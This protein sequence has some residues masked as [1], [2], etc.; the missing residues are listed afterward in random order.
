MADGS[1]V[2]GVSLDMAA[3]SASVAAMEAQI[4]GLGARI[5]SSIASSFSAGGIA[6]GFEASL[7]GVSSAISSLA[8]SISSSMRDVAA[9]SMEAFSSCDWASCG[10]AA[11]V[12]IAAGINSGI[13]AVTSAIDSITSA[14]RAA[15]SGW[16]S[17]GGDMMRGIASGIMAA[18][19]E[20]VSAV[21]SVSQ[22]ATDAAK[23]YYRI[24]SP[25]ALMRDEVGI[26]ISRGIA[27][28]I[29]SG[30]RFVENAM[31]E[32]ELSAGGTYRTDNSKRTLTQNIYLRD[33]DTTPY[34]SAKRIK[35][36]SEMMFRV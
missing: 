11:A 4:A 34:T 27:E 2:I 31:K 19:G 6:G 13:G 15:F 16:E 24:S 29:V 22:K 25:S 33:S 10:S 32:C 9:K 3:F 23:S 20:V 12:G 21:R 14:L 30:K 26:M 35:K 18:G 36:E 17:I 28:G 5:N 7:F 1:V 8:E